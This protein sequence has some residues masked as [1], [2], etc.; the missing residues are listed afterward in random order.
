MTV[1]EME[2]SPLHRALPG[3]VVRN[4]EEVYGIEEAISHSQ[5]GSVFA[6]RDVWGNPRILRQVRPFSRNYENLRERWVEDVARLQRIQHPGVVYIQDGFE[7]DGVFHLVVERCDYRLDQYIA[8]PV[9]DGGRWFRAVARPVLCALEHLH[10]AGYTH[11]N[12]HPRNVF[13]TTHLERLCPDSIFSGAIKLGDVEVNTLLGNLDVLN[14]KIP[15]WLVPPEYLNTSELG[16]MDHRMD[17]YQAGLLLLCVLQGRIMRYSFEEISLG[18][19]A[20][21]AEKLD[22]SYGQ[23]IARALQLKVADRFQTA[24]EF[25]RALGSSPRL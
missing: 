18:L 13:C 25:W 22:S 10:R 11:K 12:L 24:L 17:I 2:R 7:I 21:N 23:V 15:R 3:E 4:G 9:W 14:A 1:S 16:P 5:F 6:C 8:S 20:R 19:P